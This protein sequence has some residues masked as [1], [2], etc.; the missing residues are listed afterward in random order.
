MTGEHVGYSAVS[1]GTAVAVAAVTWLIDLM[2]VACPVVRDWN[3]V[4]LTALPPVTKLA[5]WLH[6]GLHMACLVSC[7]EHHT[8]QLQGRGQVAAADSKQAVGLAQADC[9]V[10][11]AVSF[12]RMLAL[13]CTQH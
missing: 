7:P 2:Q 11:Q 12:L 5:L 10:A 1:P 6:Q 4:M 9:L 3:D 13:G 8:H